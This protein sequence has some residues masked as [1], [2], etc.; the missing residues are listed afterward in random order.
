MKK[1]SPQETAKILAAH[2]GAKSRNPVLAEVRNLEVG[3][4]LLIESK[5]WLTKTS[6]VV[7]INSCFRDG[8]KYTIKTLA[9]GAGWICTRVN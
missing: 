8:R 4:T 2:R 3:E 1:L 9:K 6:P 5:D 7:I